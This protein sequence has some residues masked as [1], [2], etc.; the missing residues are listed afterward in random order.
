MV[1]TSNMSTLSHACKPIKAIETPYVLKISKQRQ[2]LSLDLDY[3]DQKYH[4]REIA[5]KK[6]MNGLILT[7]KSESKRLIP[8]W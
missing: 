1:L 2:C 5:E 8:V 4:T 6:Q 7:I 3:L